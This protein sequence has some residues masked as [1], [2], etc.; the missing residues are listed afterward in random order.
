MD[1]LYVKLQEV[2]AEEG[3]Q[4]ASS[5]LKQTAV[6]FIICFAYLLPPYEGEKIFEQIDTH[7]DF[8]VPSY[9]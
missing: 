6:I 1:Q 3:K 8:L 5:N 4:K 7:L 2:K 9:T